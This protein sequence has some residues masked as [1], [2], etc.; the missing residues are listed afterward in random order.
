MRAFTKFCAI[1]ALT[2]FALPIFAQQTGISGRV[3][4]PS[5]SVV[6]NVKVTAT[7]EDGTTLNTTTNASGLYQFPVLRAGTVRLRY[8]VPGF[9]PAERTVTL[10]VGQ[11]PTIDVAL[12]LAQTSSTVNVETEA[13]AVEA[14]TSQVAADISPTE[15]QKLPLN[16]RNYLQLAMMVP[17][18]TSNDVQNSPLGT[19]DSG[20][21]QINVDGQQVTQNS[22]GTSFGQPIFSEDAI[23]QYQIITNRF[24]ATMGRSSRLQVNVQTKSGT[25]NFHGSLFGYFRNSDFN[26]SDPV[27]H[28]VLPFSDQMFGGSVGGPIKKDKLFFFFS[29]EG[30]RQP[31]TIF[32]APTA[33]LSPTGQQY[34]FTFANILNTRAYLLHMDY[35][36][37]NNQR[38]SVRGSGSTYALPFANVTGTSA[39]T[40]ATNATRTFYAVTGTWTWTLTP[41][42]VNEAK[43]GFD[44][45][46]W[47]NTALINTQEYRNLDGNSWGSPYNYPQQLGQ[48]NTQFRDDMFWL[49]GN[50]SVKFGADYQH[51]PYS[52][53]F[54]Q[55][56][57]GTVLGFTSAVTSVPLYQIFPYATIFQPSTWN[58]ALLNPYV[59][60]YTQGFGNY[61]YNL[62]TNNTGAWVQDDWKVNN[63]LTLNLGV[64]Y[65]NDLGIFNPNL[66][67]TGPGAPATPHYNQNLLF[68]P[69]F[70]FAYDVTGSR[71]TVIRGGAGLFYAD[72]QANQ[73]IDDSIFNGQT[74]LS[75]SINPTAANPINLQQQ[76]T[77]F[78]V[79]GVQGVTGQ[80][81]L[82]G[83][84]PVSI[85]SIQPLGPNVKTPYSLQMSVGV[86]HQLTKDWTF[87]ADYVH[88]R[89]YHDWERT[90]ANLFYN[91]ATGYPQNP[92]TFGRPD[93]Y[94]SSILN[95]TTPNAAGSIYNALQV[96][97]TH[98]FAQSFSTQVAYTLSRLKDSTTGPFYYPDNQM[99]LNAEW[100][101]SPDNQTNTL[102]IAPSYTAKWGVVLSGQFHYGSGQNFQDLSSQNPY[103]LSGVNDRLFTAGSP[104]YGPSSCVSAAPTD[105]GFDIAHRDC[106]V[107]NQI[108][109]LDLRLSKTFTVHEHFRFIPMVEAFNLFNHSNFGNYQLNVNAAS[110]GAP[111][112]VTDL[113]Y[114]PRMLQ[115]VG[116][117]EF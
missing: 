97:V 12:Q 43:I 47:S 113:P 117:F 69:R 88:F 61:N 34:T 64:R 103:S 63:K 26:A 44:H 3:T 21:L 55:N 32:D 108:V 36:I 91:P 93:P 107:G 45:F 78:N 33:Y 42:L 1:L 81:F 109:R 13:N 11:V 57:R 29:F 31:S 17:G 40:R 20:K 99:N 22:A 56:L 115:F 79:G 112:Q 104:F 27:A 106:L 68:Q 102:T 114:Y 19:T 62:P 16:G 8:E 72:I 4:D 82:S 35:Q 2:L 77:P 98:R 46:A 51:V 41:A 70:G 10:L 6:A 86:E 84:V 54:G 18:I 49:K 15:V 52:G 59:T 37:N 90:D 25:N 65:D 50:H 89:I 92:N 110:F 105:P 100:A 96:A 5:G 111:A 71:K 48:N 14:S 66:H 94:Y 24:D 101:P 38:L 116:R 28:K 7:L 83:Q 60:S 75:P 80:Q 67:L 53:D 73:S 58:I 87:S 74:T 95:F 39:P 23:D 9:A 85:Q 30:E 76:P